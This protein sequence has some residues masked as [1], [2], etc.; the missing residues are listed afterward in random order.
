MSD[1]AAPPS[2][3]I[4]RPEFFRRVYTILIIF[5]TVGLLQL[6]IVKACDYDFYLY[7]PV[8]S[9]M[10]LLIALGCLMT[11]LCVPLGHDFPINYLLG[12]IATEALTLSV[13]NR[14]Y[15]L[16][17]V[18]WSYGIL[19]VAIILSI[20]LYLIGIFMPLKLLPGPLTILVVTIVAI[21]TLFSLLITRLVLHYESLEFYIT[22]MTLLYV[23]LIVV[24]TITMV[25]DRRLQPLPQEQS[26]L[27]VIV[28]AALFFYM[29]HM[30]GVTVLYAVHYLKITSA[31]M[32]HR[33][34]K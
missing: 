11:L 5:V 7:C 28:L 12:I 29:V 34:Q 13:L 32:P 27:P 19:V 31:I 23:M 14:D 8:P 16:L 26:M 21:A 30:I 10:W 9:F 2:Q 15:M 22:V 20:C 6:V 1:L 17:T 25:H 33:V 4:G 24:F 18:P 3:T